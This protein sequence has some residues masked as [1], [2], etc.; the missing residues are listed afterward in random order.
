MVVATVVLTTYNTNE[1]VVEL[2]GCATSGGLVISQN[3]K[4]QI[5]VVMVVV[6]VLFDVSIS[7]RDRG[8]RR[9]ARSYQSTDA[10]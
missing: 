2:W 9:P 3:S 6:V 8:C 1:N 4:I 7:F 5:M 10:L